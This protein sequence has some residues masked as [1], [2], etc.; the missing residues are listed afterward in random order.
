MA[1]I[2]LLFSTSAFRAVRLNLL[3]SF[4]SKKLTGTDPQTKADGNLVSN[5]NLNY[6]IGFS[7]GLSTHWHLLLGY[8]SRSYEI[9][10]IQK[11]DSS[12]SYTE[13]NSNF[14]INYTVSF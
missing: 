9:H 8:G 14:N 7:I 1:P 10:N 6:G 3:T 4:S 13:S 11:S 2:F 5:A 12:L